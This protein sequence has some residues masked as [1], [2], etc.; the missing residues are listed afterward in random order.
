MRENHRMEN[1][2]DIFLLFHFTSETLSPNDMI[3]RYTHTEYHIIQVSEKLERILN[4]DFTV[5]K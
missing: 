3:H 2:L 1:N 5:L 4:A